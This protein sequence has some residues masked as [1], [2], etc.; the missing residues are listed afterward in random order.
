MN[1][2]I[3]EIDR[4]PTGTSKRLPSSGRP[5]AARTAE[6]I[7][8]VE[9]LVLSLK[10]LPQTHRKL[11]QRQIAREF[12]ISQRSVNLIVKKDLRLICMK[13]RWAHKLTLANKQT[14]L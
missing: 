12:G 7:G 14:T 13:K 3:R 6:K 4:R 8:E 11:T 1:K 9:T 5:R 10:D 2:I